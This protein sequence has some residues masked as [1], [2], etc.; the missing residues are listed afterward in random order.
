[1][2]HV[3]DTSYDWHIHFASMSQIPTRNFGE[4]ASLLW[5]GDGCKPGM[6]ADER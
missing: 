1:M 2:G 3:F 6:D 4:D 5:M